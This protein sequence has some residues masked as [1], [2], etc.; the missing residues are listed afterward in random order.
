MIVQ[1][2]QRGKVELLLASA[3]GFYMKIYIFCRAQ[4]HNRNMKYWHRNWTLKKTSFPPPALNTHKWLFL[5]VVNQLG[6]FMWW[7]HSACPFCWSWVCSNWV[8][9]KAIC[10]LSVE[11]GSLGNIQERTQHFYSTIMNNVE[12]HCLGTLWYNHSF[13]AYWIFV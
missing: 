11:D 10:S 12:T 4:K 9:T 6:N 13:P 7:T 1:D 8:F 3:V 2:H 5:N